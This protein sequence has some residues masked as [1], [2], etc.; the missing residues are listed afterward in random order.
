MKSIFYAWQREHEAGLRP[1]SSG[2]YPLNYNQI[3]RGHN[4]AC[5]IGKKKPNK[6]KHTHT[7]RE[8]KKEREILSSRINGMPFPMYRHFVNKI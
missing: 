8:I 5:A 6:G 7:K 2:S 1:V 3:L 4:C